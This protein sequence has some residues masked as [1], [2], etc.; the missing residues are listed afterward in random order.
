LLRQIEVAGYDDQNNSI[1]EL[2]PLSFAY[3][4]FAP[5]KQ[6]FLSITRAD[7]PPASL[8][9]P[10]YELADL[11][12][13]GLPDILEMNGTVRYW[14]NLGNGTF[15][16][17]RPMRDAPAGLA[18]ADVGVQ[19]IDADGDGRIDLLASKDGLFGYFPLRFD[20][21]WDRSSFRRYES[22]P[23]FNLEDPEVKLVDLDGDGITDVIR[24]GTRLECFFHDRKKGWNGRT[25]WRER[26]ALA[27]FPNVNF[28]DPRVKWGDM[29]GDGLQNIVLVYDGNVEYWPNL[30]Y[31]NW[32]K[33]IHMR[34]SPRFPYG[35]DPKRILLGDVDGDGLADIVY[36]DDRKVML[37]INH[38]GNEWSGS[39]TVIEGTPPV[40]DMDAVRLVD[41]LGSGIS[42][43][44]W[45]ADA[46]INSRKH[47][48]FLDFTG[49]IKPYLLHE[50]DNHLGAVTKVE[51]APSTKFYV[52]DRVNPRSRWKT[53]L[54]FPVHVVARVEVIDD[55]SRCKLTTE[56]AY[57][58]G[59]WDGSER[60]FRGFGMV[61]QFDT[62]TFDL[63]KER[64]L[65]GAA[66]D[67]SPVEQVH[68]SLPTRTKTWFHQGPVG[69]EYGGWDELKYEDF[70]E[71]DP[72][73]LERPQEMRTFLRSLPRRVKRDAL[74]ALRG[75]ILRTELYALDDADPARRKRPYTVTES[76]YGVC[77]VVAS[78]NGLP[79]VSC[80]PQQGDSAEKLGGDVP[81]RIFFP[82][83]L[84]QRTTQWERGDDPMTQFTFTDEFDDFGQP[85][86][87]TAVAM[88]RRSANRHSVT[89][90]VVGHIQPDE[91]SVLATHTST[92]YAQPQGDAYTHDRVAQVKLYALANPHTVNENKP[93]AIE[94]QA[95]R[96]L[97]MAQSNVQLIG[98]TLYHYDGPAFEGLPVGNAGK[99]GALT[100]SERLCFTDELLNAAYKGD[101]NKPGRRASYL[102]GSQQLPNGTP[103]NFGTNAGY[104]SMPASGNYHKGY[105][106][107]TKRQ[108][109]DFQVSN[110]VQQRGVVVAIQDA[111]KHETQITP[112]KYWLLPEKVTDPATLTTTAKYNYRVM[113]PE[114]ATDAN[115][116]Q[117]HYRYHPIGLPHKVWLES[118]DGQGGTEYKPEL[119]YHYDFLHY[120]N[121]KSADPQNPQP[122]YVHTTARVHHASDNISD[123]TI[124][125]YEYSDGFS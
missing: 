49:G 66:V 16:L 34:N 93:Q 29:T 68:F 61:E 105:Y 82:H 8:A 100:Q 80:A 54:P 116:N 51:F 18:L 39:P 35:Y 81:Q 108:K 58:H 57:H 122:I 88:P 73:L 4:Q 85:Q 115:G 27:D 71:E 101:P 118:N 74:R 55:I 9:H 67:F 91:T 119:E 104:R 121:S 20:A 14:R 84:A 64:G 17:P 11:T 83:I 124:E 24:S 89:G 120:E 114:V 99:Y 23:S 5:Q 98:H 13:D 96:D 30:G 25:V 113:Q 21:L 12:G 47:M 56:Y 3:T 102:D 77:E 10:D 52:Q 75:S 41:M 53:P 103:P 87:Q 86:R 72:Q 43:V 110:L 37:W 90:A 1:Q 42:G 19:L 26:R 112:D 50:M 40:T 48:F 65:H 109:F 78:N 111:L 106:A 60:E 59:Y 22:P 123:E 2:P 92:T 79:T 38:S 95:V 31:G 33:R 94:A 46:T 117:T 45:S 44:L 15:D 6:K 125:T 36:V 69:D 7:L 107:D 62:E 70:W 32:G 97:F 76:L 28:S 63:Y